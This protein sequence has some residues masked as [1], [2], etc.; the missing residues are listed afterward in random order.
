MYLSDSD[1]LAREVA[2]L[3][4]MLRALLDAELAAGN[5]V[6]SIGHS[7]PAPP[8]GAFLQMARPIATRLRATGGGLLFR[9]HH[10]G[11]YAAAF[12]DADGRYFLL[13]PPGEPPPE[14]D[15]DAI[16]AAH[17]GK[18]VKEAN[19][20]NAVSTGNSGSVTTLPASS[21]ADDAMHRF[22]R[23]MVM[24][25]EKWHD[26][27]GYDLAAL[28]SATPLERAQ[29][30]ILLLARTPEDWRDIEALA[31]LD[32]PRARAVLA[33]MLAADG[34]VALQLAV[35]QYGRCPVPD[36]QRGAVLLRALATADFYAGLTQALDMVAA[37]HPSEVVAGLWQGLG[38][39]EGPVAVHFAAMLC[40]VHGL[41]DSPF[42]MAQRPFFLR[43]H[44][45]RGPAREAA[46]AELRQRIAPVHTGEPPGDK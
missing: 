6:T 14:P 39:R 21:A 45:T 27:T 20:A 42:D 1:L 46:I 38:S 31:K 30:E 25:Y 32:T 44:C 23:S 34:P 7:F 3:P 18:A 10:G 33:R 29:I 16:R 4:P 43:F 41:A 24:D 35:L 40:F 13:D 9:A 19:T 2:A 26:G 5:Q 28:A 22:R 37:F 15:M 17:A 11:P 12:T 36:A 8:I